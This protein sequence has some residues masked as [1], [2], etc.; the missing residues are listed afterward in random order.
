MDDPNY[1]KYHWVI[2]HLVEKCFV[3]KELILRLARQKKIELDMEEVAQTNHAADENPGVVACHAINTTEEESIPLRS[4]EKEEVSK[5][6][7]RFNVDDLLS[8]PQETKT[9]LINALLNSEAS[10]LSAPT[11]TYES[12]PLLGILVDELS[13]CKLV[14]QGFNR[15]NQRIHGNGVVTS[16]LH[17]CFKFYQD[18]VK[19]VEADSN[20]FLEAKSHF[21]NA[22]FYLKN[23]NSPKAMSVEIPLVNKEDNL[24]LKSL[25]SRESHKNT[26]TFNS[27]KCEAST[28][29]TKILKESFTTSLTNI[30]KQ[31]VKID[32]MEASLPQRRTKDGFDPKAYKLMAKAGPHVQTGFSIDRKKKES[33]SHASV[34][35]RIKHADVES[36]HCKEFPCEVKR[37]DVILTN[38][39]KE[40]SEQ[41]EGEISCHHITILKELEIETPKEDAEDVPQ[42]LEDGGQSTVDELKEVN[43]DEEMTAFRTP[44]E[45]YCYKVMPFGL[46]NVGAAYQRAM[47]KVFDDMLHK[48]VKC[49]INDLVV[50][51]KRRHDHLKDLKVVFDRLRK[52]QLRINP[53]KCVFS[54]TTGKFLGFIAIKGQELADFLADHPIPSDWKLCVDLPDDEVFFTKVMEPWTMYFDGIMRRSGAGAGIVLISP[55]KHV[56]PYSFALAELC[57]NNVVEY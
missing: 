53:L 40:N 24:Q 39:E 9:I 37:H 20:P 52:Y 42:S 38:P 34:W 47:Q 31:E 33:T 19:K 28:S 32:L 4:L 3:L 13:N 55:E 56:L 29:T 25:A 2:S 23:D 1:C 15:G 46:K 27:G 21:A 10:S 18:G 49:Y 12:T 26:G 6:L 14:I 41:G 45:I 43:L 7:S 51:S 17:Q 54:V 8:L 22:K 5:D 50:K 57:S 11:A 48:Y 35:C 44:K 30:T 36:F 16:I